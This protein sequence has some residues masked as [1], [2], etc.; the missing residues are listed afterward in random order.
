M[1]RC[2]DV[3]DYLSAT[4]RS[5]VDAFMERLAAAHS[6]A[7]NTATN[8]SRLNHRLGYRTDLH[9]E[10]EI[11]EAVE[12]SANDAQFRRVCQLA[13]RYQIPLDDWLD[14]VLHPIQAAQHEQ[15]QSQ[16]QY[17]H[18]LYREETHE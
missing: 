17:L 8:A 4:D 13:F 3:L 6:F 2:D 9:L 11:A 7:E 16:I 10:D 15:K 18:R 1:A 5:L 14:V 12:V